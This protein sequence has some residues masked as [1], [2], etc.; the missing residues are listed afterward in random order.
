MI[1]RPKFKRNKII[2]PPKSTRFCINCERR[3]VFK[4]NPTVLHSECV[5]CGFRYGKNK[6]FNKI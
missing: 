3:T 5:E 6:I 4:Y 1:P 2:K